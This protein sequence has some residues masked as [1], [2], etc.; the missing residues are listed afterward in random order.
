MKFKYFF[1]RKLFFVKEADAFALFPGGFGT[2]DE[3]FEVLTLLQTGKTPPTPVI[4]MELPGDDYWQAWDRFIREQLLARELLR[5]EDLSFYEIVHSPQEGVDRITDYYST[6]HSARQVRDKLVIR[7]E[8][9]LSD[10]VI[11]GLNCSFQDVIE[12][13]EITRT[14]ALS[15]EEDE[16]GLWIK[17]RISFHYNK[18]NAGRLNEMILAINSS[19]HP[20]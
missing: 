7:L 17:P 20:A 6:Y 11:D 14:S 18:K 9:E 8:K 3:G 15:D 13:G 4:L 5:P 2:H 16:P 1:T 12:S 19:G 10:E